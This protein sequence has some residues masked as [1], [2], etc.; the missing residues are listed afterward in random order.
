MSGEKRIQPKI[1]MEQLSMAYIHAIASH[2]GFGADKPLV[3]HDSIDL[4]ISSSSGRKVK[5]DI[6]LKSTTTFTN[7]QLLSE[8]ISF[9]LPINNYND[10]RTETLC[11]RILVVFCMPSNESE[12]IEHSTEQLILRKCAYW[13]SLQGEQD[14][15][16]KETITIRI[17]TKNIFSPESLEKLMLRIDK[18]EAINND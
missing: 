14:T 5:L 15:T 17:P 8:N 18:G 7:E 1:R 2:L 3:D 6:Q 9:H 16:N 10:L 4:T 13:I 11:P 12:W